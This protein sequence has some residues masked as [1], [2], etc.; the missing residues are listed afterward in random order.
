MTKIVVL[1]DTWSK[2]DA[3]QIWEEMLKASL[4]PYYL[5][6]EIIYLENRAGAFKWSTEVKENVKEAFGDPDYIK[7]NIKGAEIVLSG[8]APMTASVMDSD[9]ALKVIGIAR[10]GPVN[11]DVAAATSRRVMVVGTVGRNAESRRRSD[12]R[13]HPLRVP[14]HR[15]P[16]HGTEDR[17]ILRAIHQDGQRQVPR[18]LRL[19]RARREDPRPHRVRRG[20]EDASQRGRTPSE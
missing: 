20:W 19:P 6:H 17:I 16:Q 18:S 3:K 4:G 15:A 1:Y 10:G 11:V 12:P 2:A 9:P 8:F 5:K 14:P 7:Q 13:L